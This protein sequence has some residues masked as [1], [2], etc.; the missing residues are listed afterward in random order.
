MTKTVFEKHYLEQFDVELKKL[1][2]PRKEERVILRTPSIDYCFKKE[3]WEL[4]KEKLN[5]KF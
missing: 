3:D 1:K 5:K 4:V 2:N